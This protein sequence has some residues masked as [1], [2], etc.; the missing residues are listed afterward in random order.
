[1][2]IIIDETESVTLNNMLIMLVK[3]HLYTIY[4]LCNIDRFNKTFILV[5]RCLAPSRWQIGAAQIEFSWMICGTL[6]IGIIQDER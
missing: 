2:D 1:M 3:S 5:G 6:E 4:V